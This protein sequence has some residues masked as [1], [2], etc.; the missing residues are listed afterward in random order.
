MPVFAI[1]IGLI[2]FL[3]FI[4][5][6]IY[7]DEYRKKRLARKTAKADRF[8]DSGKE[9][10][11]QVRIDTEVDVSY[12][13]VSGTSTHKRTSISRNIS[14]SGINLALN[15]KLLPGTDLNLQLDLPQGVKP[16]FVQGKIVWV[17]EIS[18]R[19]TRQKKEE[20]F[21]AT[22]IQF[23]QMSPRDESLLHSFIDQH[24][25]NAVKLI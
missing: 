1:Q 2:V 20:R 3:L 17:K 19:L 12:E 23:T 15:E 13:I 9:R 6:V 24:I 14:L 22:G 25:K 21:F 16:I 18:E 10:R 8:W 5:A 7:Q 11:Q 4:L